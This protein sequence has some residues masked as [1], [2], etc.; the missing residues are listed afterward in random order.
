AQALQD[1]QPKP[2]LHRYLVFLRTGT[3]VDLVASGAGK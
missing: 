1:L 2:V 3:V